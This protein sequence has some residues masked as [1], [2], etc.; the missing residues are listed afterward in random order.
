MGGWFEF[1]SDLE[2]KGLRVSSQFHK[3]FLDDKKNLY[4]GRALAVP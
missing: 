4:P 2:I 1:F 3:I